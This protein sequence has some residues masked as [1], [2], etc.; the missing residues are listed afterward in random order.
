MITALEITYRVK[1]GCADAAR[2]DLGLLVR[3][4]WA[5]GY[6]LGSNWSVRLNRQQTQASLFAYFTGHDAWNTFQH[7]PGSGGELSIEALSRDTVGTPRVAE[8][9]RPWGG[10]V[11][12]CKCRK[13]ERPPLDL[14]CTPRSKCPPLMCSKG[15]VIPYYA[16]PMQGLTRFQ[17][18]QWHIAAQSL[19]CIFL[20]SQSLYRQM[21]EKEL[22]DP[23]SVLSR[24]SVRLA[25]EASAQLGRK[26]VARCPPIHLFRL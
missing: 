15:G 9:K 2:V 14:W 1:P 11:P 23:K 17:L 22:N 5:N 6:I 21:A 25:H 10:P 16:L 24:E 4:L 8:H 18:H 13:G 12:A 3:P 19:A 26:V 20:D 7:D